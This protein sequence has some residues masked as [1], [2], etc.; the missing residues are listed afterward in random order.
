MQKGCRE[1][2]K[3][4]YKYFSDRM[5]EM[6]HLLY[7][8]FERSE[9]SKINKLNEEILLIRD[10]HIV[11]EDMVDDLISDQNIPSNLKNQMDGKEV[12]HI[13]RDT[14]FFAEDDIYY[15]GDSKYYKAKSNIG[16]LSKAKQFTYAKNVIQFNIDLFNRNELGVGLKYRDL[17]TEGYNVTPNFFISA[18]LNKDLSF[19]KSDL[20]NTNKPVLNFQFEN[21]LFDRDTL[22]LQSYKINFLFLLSSYISKNQSIKKAFKKSARM[23]FKNEL[24]E[25]LQDRYTFYEVYS[26]ENFLIKDSFKLLNGKIYKT[27]SQNSSFILALENSFKYKEE[28]ATILSLIYDRVGDNNIE[29]YYLDNSVYKLNKNIVV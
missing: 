7:V 25:Y 15:I 28:N 8:F 4:K 24:V 6:Y 17:D 22:L 9:K 3:I 23:K 13:Y 20:E 29:E 10:F 16:T 21:R 1:L 11:F 26:L 18:M 5:K 14:S 27:S 2:K 19:H 12:D